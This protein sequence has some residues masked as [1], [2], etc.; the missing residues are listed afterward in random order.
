MNSTK[1][2]ATMESLAWLYAVIC[3]FAACLLS[4]LVMAWKRPQK[5]E[6]E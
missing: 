5:P 3:R 6:G 1:A 4:C 2:S